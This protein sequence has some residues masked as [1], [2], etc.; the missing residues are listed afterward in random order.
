M[1]QRLPPLSKQSGE[2]KFWHVLL[3]VLVVVGFALFINAKGTSFFTRTIPNSFNF[4]KNQDYTSYQPDYVERQ[5][6]NASYYREPE[7]TDPDLWVTE[8]SPVQQQPSSI[9]QPPVLEEYNDNLYSDDT[10][11]PKPSYTYDQ[12]YP[13]RLSRGY[14]TVQVFTGYNSKQAYDLRAALKKDGYS[15]THI[16]ELRTR[17]GVLFKLRIGRYKER[18]AAFAVRD[19]LRRRYPRTLPNSFVMLIEAEYH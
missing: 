3:I 18:Y 17:K 19:Q 11:V 9:P 15:T 8:P 5:A 12:Q 13:P 10:G 16:R 4:N 14:Y 6:A 7:D 1:K 2:F